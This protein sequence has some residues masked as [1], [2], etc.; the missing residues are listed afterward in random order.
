[1]TD[2]KKGDRVVLVSSGGYGS[3]FHDGLLGTVVSVYNQNAI[4]V[5]VDGKGHKDGLCFCASEIS[6]A[7][8]EVVTLDVYMIVRSKV[9]NP[10]KMR[11]C[12]AGATGAKEYLSK[13][14]AEAAVK[15]LNEQYGSKWKYFLVKKV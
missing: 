13:A 8:V 15:R 4:M 2:Y 9:S 10:L 7:P 3:S 1:M 12:Y 6:P 11:V 14:N 5:D